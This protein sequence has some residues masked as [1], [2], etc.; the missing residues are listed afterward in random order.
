MTLPA[1]SFNLASTIMLAGAATGA[2]IGGNHAA[3]AMQ[4]TESWV[5]NPSPFIRAF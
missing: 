2:S 1:L 5:A 4:S 3:S